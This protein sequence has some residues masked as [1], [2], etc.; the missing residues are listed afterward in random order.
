MEIDRSSSPNSIQ[1]TI[2]S[3][4]KTVVTPSN[5]GNF[6]RV[7]SFPN[8]TSSELILAVQIINFQRLRALWKNES[9]NFVVLAVLN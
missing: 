4:L 1:I 5:G 8:L 6:P 2:V 9:S 7:F 3:K